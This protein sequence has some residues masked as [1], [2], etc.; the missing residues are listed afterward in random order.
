MSPQGLV[1]ES[2]SRFAKLTANREI[3]EEE[4][5]VE[6]GGSE[7]TSRQSLYYSAKDSITA[8]EKEFF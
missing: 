8:L 1:E 5:R 7:V 4:R 3:C 6:A 2:K